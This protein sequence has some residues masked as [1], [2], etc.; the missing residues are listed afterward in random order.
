M[1][2][3]A[4]S[5]RDHAERQPRAPRWR[6]LVEVAAF[7]AALASYLGALALAS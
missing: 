5:M 2:R 6:P 4:P 7:L 1:I 3:T